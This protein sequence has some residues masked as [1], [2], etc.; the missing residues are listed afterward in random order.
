MSPI[1]DFYIGCTGRRHL[2]FQHL[3]QKYGRVVRYGPNELAFNTPQAFRDMYGFKRNVRKADAVTVGASTNPDEQST[4][5]EPYTERAM[6]KRKILSQGFSESALKAAEEYM[7]DQIKVLCKQLVNPSTE[8]VK[9]LSLWLNYLAYDIMG[10]VVF[11]KSFNMMTDP[12]LRYVLDLIDSM[13]F[14]TLLGGIMP[15]FYRTGLIGLIFPGLFQMRRRF[16]SYVGGVVQERVAKEGE[17]TS[18]GR[19]DFFHHLL[20]ARDPSTGKPLAPS[21]LFVEG[22]LLIV[23]GSDTSST[24]LAATIFYLLKHKRCMDKLYEELDNTFTDVEAIK[25]GQ[26]LTSCVY[27]KACI[28]EALRMAPPGPGVLPRTILKGGETID[29]EYLP[30]GTTVGVAW[31]ALGYN[32]NYFPNPEEYRPERYLVGESTTETEVE[33]AKESY[34]PFS[35]GPRKCPGIKMAYQELYI[36]IARLV[37]LFDITPEN[38]AE[39][40]H[41]FELLD[42]FNVKKHGPLASFQ[43]R[44]G[45]HL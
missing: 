23:G 1:Y 27:L 6:R 19:K 10:E 24:G 5:S 26:D 13:V 9:D 45:K 4:F 44:K 36:T 42:H 28:E 17:S 18:E 8:K 25:T 11:G 30:E 7:I 3:H 15:W 21:T 32:A 41:N 31:W 16:M 37:Y 33:L 14:S 22:L 43:L 40:E 29:G 12:S 38:P 35:M 39:L 2:H 34:W 20:R